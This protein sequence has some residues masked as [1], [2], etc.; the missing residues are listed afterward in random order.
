MTKLC[1]VMMTFNDV[2]N[3]IF[4][5]SFRL[6]VF[7]IT[8]YIVSQYEDCDFVKEEDT[9]HSCSFPAIELQFYKIPSRTLEI[10]FLSVQLQYVNFA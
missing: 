10:I 8:Y 4:T 9:F 7:F 6:H 2:I 1:L 3:I 5:I